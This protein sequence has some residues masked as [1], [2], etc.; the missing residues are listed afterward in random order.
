MGSGFPEEHLYS[1]V[2]LSI[3]S[4]PLTQTLL[5]SGEHSECLFCFLEHMTP[6]KSLSSQSS[7]PLLIDPLRFQPSCL[8][9]THA[10]KLS[11]KLTSQLTYNSV[12]AEEYLRTVRLTHPKITPVIRTDPW[13]TTY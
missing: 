6:P 9:F 5:T 2:L 7:D 12:S 11:R 3:S 1:S 4:N 8:W 13:Y 10:A